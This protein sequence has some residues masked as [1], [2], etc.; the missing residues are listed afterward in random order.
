MCYSFI[1]VVSETM[2]L[3]TTDLCWML[4]L[5]CKLFPVPIMHS[6]KCL[7][8]IFVR[9][10]A[11]SMFVCMH[12]NPLYSSIF[13]LQFDAAPAGAGWHKSNKLKPDALGYCRG[14]KPRRQRCPEIVM[15][16]MNTGELRPSCSTLWFSIIW[17]WEMPTRIA[18]YLWPEKVR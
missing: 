14:R 5:E 3:N 11:I 13:I 1:W 10:Y 18:T 16:G 9:W 4:I 17:E 8:S 6:D 12:F 2:Q 15:A 7:L